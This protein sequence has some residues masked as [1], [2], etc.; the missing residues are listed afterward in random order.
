[1][2]ISNLL[3]FSFLFLLKLA[4][5]DN[6][7]TWNKFEYREVTVYKYGNKSIPPLKNWESYCDDRKDMCI[8]LYCDVGWELQGQLCQQS[9]QPKEILTT[10]KLIYLHFKSDI[11]V[12]QNSTAS[13]IYFKNLLSREKYL[14]PM[15]NFD[16]KCAE[17]FKVVN[18]RY[19]I[20]S[21][22]LNYHFEEEIIPFIAFADM[23]NGNYGIVFHK[24][25]LIDVT[26]SLREFINYAEYGFWEVSVV[27]AISFAICSFLS[28]L[29]M[30]NQENQTDFREFLSFVWKYSLLNAASSFKSSKT[31][32]T[33][34]PNVVLDLLIVFP[35]IALFYTFIKSLLFST[36]PSFS[37]KKILIIMLFSILLSMCFFWIDGYPKTFISAVS[38]TAR[39]L[40]RI[41][42]MVTILLFLRLAKA[43]FVR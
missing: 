1:M 33:K 24:C 32:N 34:I 3:G 20:T 17:A 25:D 43:K 14:F 41:L 31:M 26:I 23:E 13:Q 27:A 30:K 29:L 15:K 2:L 4:N 39:F 42:N 16:T 36:A 6:S 19:T 7:I 12:D 37:V 40:L 9:T 35:T 38:L 10:K 8:G 11:P 28:F 5:G 21:I 22:W 18:V